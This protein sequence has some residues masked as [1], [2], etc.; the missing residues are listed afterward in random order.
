[1]A[2]VLELHADLMEDLVEQPV[3]RVAPRGTA[4][5]AREL[6]RQRFQV[7]PQLIGLT[8]TRQ[9]LLDTAGTHLFYKHNHIYFYYL[10]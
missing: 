4:R 2:L 3:G 7:G 8:L 6:I 1:L 10:Y 5:G 9:P